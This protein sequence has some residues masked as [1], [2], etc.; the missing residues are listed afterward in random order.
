MTRSYPLWLAPFFLINLNTLIH[1][2]W[3][4][5]SQTSN[6]IVNMNRVIS[7]GPETFGNSH[8]FMVSLSF[9]FNLLDF[10]PLT[11]L[12]LKC[13][14]LKWAHLL[15]LTI[16]IYIYC[17]MVSISVFVNYSNHSRGL[18]VNLT[19]YICKFSGVD[20]HINSSALKDSKQDIHKL[21]CNGI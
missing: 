1:S 15:W 7:L 5:K 17:S 18:S 13:L 3:H 11:F 14:N 19:S 8:H 16:Y 20:L 9:Y 2:I 4:V 12:I 10:A 6:L 21:K